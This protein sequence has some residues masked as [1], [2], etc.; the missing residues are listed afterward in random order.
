MERFTLYLCLFLAAMCV[1]CIAEEAEKPNL[2]TVIGIDLGTTYSCVGVYKN[3][4]VEIIA[5]DQGSRITPSWVAFTE[6]E[7]L[8]GEAAK[9]QVAQNPT[10]TLFD[11]KRL[12]G[13]KYADPDVQK[14]IKHYPFKVVNKDGK[15]YVQ[16]PV[17]G[18]N[19]VFSPEEAS[20]MILTKMKE[21]AEAYLGHPVENAVI[22]VPAYFKDAERQATK[23]AGQIAGLNVVRIINEPTAAAIAYGLDKKFADE[24]Y[25]LVYDLGGGTFD[26]S[27]LSIDDGVFEV[28]ATSGNTHLG[29]EDFDQR[30]V[31]HF[32]KLFRTK[33][34]KDVSKNQRCL[35]KLRREAEKAKR[36]LST[37]LQ[38]KLE[39]E[40]FH[41]GVDFSET[42]TRARF[43]ELNMDLFRSTLKTVAH[44]LEDAGLKKH[45]VHDI[46]LV[47]GSTRIPKIQKLLKDYFNGKDPR[48]D[49]NP[50]E[51]VAY[52]ASIQAGILSG[53]DDAPS[54]VIL[55][56]VTPL[57]LGIETVG[58]VMTKIVERNTVIPTKKQRT[59]TT[60]QDRQE[61]VLIQVFEGERAMTKD[62]NVLG[63]F[64]LSGIPPAQ[65]GVPQIEVSFEVDAN[66]ILSVSAEE[67]ASGQKQSIVITNNKGRL[68]QEEIDRMIEEA[69]Q[70]QE[71]DRITKERIE[72]RNEL[73]HYAYTLR[74]TIEDED[75]L[76]N[77][78]EEEEKAQIETAVKETLEWLD[79]NQESE[80]DEFAEKLKEL[81]NVANPIIS[82][83]YQEMGGQPGGPMGGAQPDF[84][85]EPEGDDMPS[86]DE[87]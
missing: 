49:I 12:I 23:D 3:G 5:N 40:S 72:S 67:K 85:G 35:Q 64:E 19:R 77:K 16:I 78:L 71:D 37:Q 76:A 57:T 38:A 15:P 65:R 25:V 44:V 10:A 60:Y 43:E 33:T 2:G 66:G 26:V 30:I 55:L 24:R 52:G 48:R 9:N 54:G 87:L 36:T 53:T 6:S 21:T 13:R 32:V 7:R 34:G 42:L 8:I 68:S 75:K 46:V 14:D 17:K 11:M 1:R 58:G 70:F 45:E 39:I 63:K 79:L 18:E 28:V 74:Q 69:A 29:G 81:Q 56:D 83:V 4:R 86:H 27:L 61:M 31:D 80:K 51:A 73:E 47:G 50:D 59:F 22:T 82:K 20:A 41:E 62:N 84:D